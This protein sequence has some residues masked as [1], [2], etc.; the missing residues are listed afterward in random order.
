MKKLILI[1]IFIFFTICSKS[2]AGELD[3][4]GLICECIKKCSEDNVDNFKLFLFIDDKVIQHRIWRNDAGEILDERF[5]SGPLYKLSPKIIE[6]DNNTLN[7]ETLILQ[8]KYL[9]EVYSRF[10]L[11]VEIIN[12]L[13]DVLKNQDEEIK[14]KNKI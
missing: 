8:N 9:C 14:S 2:W 5:V 1:G 10:K 4:K 6:W 12:N 13:I 11:S 3:G 7:R